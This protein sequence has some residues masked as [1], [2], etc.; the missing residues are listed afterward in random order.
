MLTSYQHALVTSTNPLRQ[1]FP[2]RLNDN[3]H[4]PTYSMASTAPHQS[5]LPHRTTGPAGSEGAVPDT[6]PGETSGLL[7]ERLQAWKHMCAYLEDYICEVAKDQ[8]SQAKEQEKMLK[9]INKPL[10]EG[11]HFEQSLGGV[12]G[13]FENIRA[14]TTAQANLH[15][16]TSKNLTGSVLPILERLHTEIKNKNKEL[17]SGANKGAKAVDKAR[18]ASQKYI[19]ALGQHTADFDS[20]G[21]RIAAANDPYI[22]QRG[23][24]YRL[25]KQI[26]EENNNRQDLLSVQGSFQQFEAHVVQTMQATLNAFNQYMG[27]QADRQRALYADIAHKAQRI[28]PDFE[29]NGFVTLNPNMLIDPNGPPRRMSHIAYPNQDHKATKALIEGILEV[30]KKGGI[31]SL[32]GYSSGYFAV[33]PAG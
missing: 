33:T 32:K 19:E 6:D 18:N 21:G 4:P 7:L 9:V 22:L 29:W 5:E 8:K 13:L 15:V 25:N 23:L 14:N 1:T 11:H 2:P 26:L 20:A 31:S 24:R 30:K 12:A 16:E 10:K 27:G 3:E 28:P 17:N